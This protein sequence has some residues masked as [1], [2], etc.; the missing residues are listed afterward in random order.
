MPGRALLTLAIC[1]PLVAPITL[2]ANTGR[3]DSIKTLAIGDSITLGIS[4][5]PVGPGYAQILELENLGCGGANA[6]GWRPEAGLSVCLARDDNEPLDYWDDLILP[7]LPAD[8]ATILLGTNDAVIG[9]PPLW[10]EGSLR[11]LIAGLVLVGVS[12]VV[13]MTPPPNFGGDEEVQA[14]LNVYVGIIRQLCAEKP[15]V[16]CGPE[17]HTLLGPEDFAPGNVHPNATG[18]AKIAD[19]LFGYVVPEPSTASLLALGLAG[20][21]VVGRRRAN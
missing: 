9:L 1:A 16:T 14:M 6:N 3:A 8:Q 5:S 21:A 12:D 10:Y 20:I 7:A 2:G 19:A 4:S 13:L 17:L 18:H 15:A 11:Q